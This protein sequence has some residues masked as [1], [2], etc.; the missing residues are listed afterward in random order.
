MKLQ[1][2]ITTL[3]LI[4]GQLAFSQENLSAEEIADYQNNLMTEELE[5]TEVQQERVSEI[6]KRYAIEQK[7]LIEQE[8]SMFGKMGEMKK[9]KREKNSELETVLTKEQFEKYEDDLAPQIR[10]YMRKNMSM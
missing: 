9:I 4:I 7:S 3:L 2:L 10:N 1:S 6:N 8:G 5:L